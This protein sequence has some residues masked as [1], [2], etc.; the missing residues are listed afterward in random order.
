MLV[1]PKQ[2]IEQ[3]FRIIKVHTSTIE[4]NQESITA[5]FSRTHEHLN[6]HS[7]EHLNSNSCKADNDWQF[8]LIGQCE[9]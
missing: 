8:L 2:N 9:K 4:K 1:G 7:H 6:S 5:A 3:D